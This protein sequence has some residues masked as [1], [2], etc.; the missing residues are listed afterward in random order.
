MEAQHDG[1]K[2]VKRGKLNV[3]GV[4]RGSWVS[5]REKFSGRKKKKRVAEPDGG[6]ESLEMDYP[7][8]EPRQHIWEADR[9]GE[10]V[11]LYAK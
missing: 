6:S 7:G 2:P 8:R 3:E 11:W 4:L 9:K 5:K 1:I 10:Q